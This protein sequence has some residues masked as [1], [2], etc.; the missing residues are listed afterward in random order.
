MSLIENGRSNTQ[1]GE[2]DKQRGIVITFVSGKGGVGKTALSL[3]MATILSA[4]GKKV[5]FVDFDLATHGA[6]YFF[7]DEIKEGKKEGIIEAIDTVIETPKKLESMKILDLVSC[8]KT[9]YDFDLIPSKTYFAR[10]IFSWLRKNEPKAKSI[11]SKILSVS[12]SS[13]NFIIVDA[14]AGA[15]TSASEAVR[16]SDKVVIPSEPDPISYSAVKNLEYEFRKYFPKDTFYVLNS[17]FFKEA[18]MDAAV[19]KYLK[20][21]FSHLPPI[22][23][24]FEVR[25]SF[26]RR[27][28]PVD[29]EEPSAF[30][31]GI[32]RMMRDLLTELGKEIEYFQD[33]EF[34]GP[35]EA[36]IEKINNEVANIRDSTEAKTREGRVFLR[37]TMRTTVWSI[38]GLVGSISIYLIFSGFSIMSPI[39]VTVFVILGLVCGVMG[40][41]SY[42]RI[43]SHEDEAELMTWEREK[44]TGQ[45]ETRRESF[46][47]L[48]ATRRE[49]LLGEKREGSVRDVED[50]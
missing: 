39:T 32:V 4:M 12:K 3:G 11:L 9:R 50:S 6:T 1:N 45:L 13:Y 42:S 37:R 5:L 15:T 36:K 21:M 10:S 38:L 33:S 40:H 27:I 25:R 19:S 24:D 41:W 17:L 44:E 7:I 26:A 43:R 2:T 34:L 8:F 16:Q 31:F 18:G 20:L 49:K 47:T 29:L 22:P 28:V 23:F 46:E 48:L 14:Q 30:V 35:I